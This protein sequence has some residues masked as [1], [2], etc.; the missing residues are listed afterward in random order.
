MKILAM[1]IGY[2]DTKVM[3]ENK[4]FIYPS[5]FAPYPRRELGVGNSYGIACRMTGR[6]EIGPFIV[7]EKAQLYPGFTEPIEPT[8]SAR[9]S[10]DSVIPLIGE[11]VIRSGASGTVVLS[12][13]APLDLY[14]LERAGIRDFTGK[15]LIVETTNGLRRE[16]TIGSVVSRPQG[17]AAAVALA[18]EGLFPSIPGLGVVIDIGSRTTDIVTVSLSDDLDPVKP[19]CFSI[20][21]GIRDFLNVIADAIGKEC[22]GFRPKRQLIQASLSKPTFTVGK[23]S[24]LLPVF[25][26]EARKSIA[27]MLS[28]EILSR[29]GE[30]SGFVTAVCGVGGGASPL[31]LGKTIHTL[32]PG[33]QEVLL[34]E[35]I[36]PEYLNVMGYNVAAEAVEMAV[37]ATR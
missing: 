32:F 20:P 19:L 16:I 29:F 9:L 30:Q 35:G 24:V 4:K 28:N 7:G 15:H 6:P 31:L 1:D 13:G 25:I 23:K 27:T 22:Q 17:V 11:A 5:G 33:A 21:V 18:S 8:G 26:Q 2:G 3:Y 37:A 34:P 36:G 14:A 10:S 12:T